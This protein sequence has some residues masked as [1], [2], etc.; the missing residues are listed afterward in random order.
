MNELQIQLNDKACQSAARQAFPRRK[1]AQADFMRGWAE[2]TGCLQARAMSVGSDAEKRG[3][4]MAEIFLH[5]TDFSEP[6]LF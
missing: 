4:A 5:M 6:T 2:R 1:A 3:F